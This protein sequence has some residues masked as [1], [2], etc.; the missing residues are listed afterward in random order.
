MFSVIKGLLTGVAIVL[1]TS[2]LT[3]VASVQATPLQDSGRV[4]EPSGSTVIYTAREFITMDPKKPRAEAVAVKDGR[5]IAVGTRAEVE[6]A[7]GAGARTDTT[8][9]DRV[10]VPGLIEQHVHPLLAALT[11]VCEVISIEDWNT[12]NGFAPKALDQAAYRERL[13]KTIADY[14]PSSGSTLFTWGYHESWHGPMSRQILDSMAPDLP[15]AVWDRST[16]VMFLNTAAM[17]EYEIDAK[18]VTTLSQAAQ[19]QINLETGKFLEAGFFEGLMDRIAKGLANPERLNRGLEYAERYF[20]QQ[21]I[22]I[23][24]EPAGPLSKPMQDAINAVFGDDT[25]P[26]NFFYIPDGRMIAARYLDKEGGE[27]L[28][29][30]HDNMMS[31]G[32]GRGHFLPKQTKLLMDGAIFSQ[33]QQM[34]DGY[35]DD[36]HGEWIQAPDLF[37]RAFNVYWSAGYQI[38]VHVLG[39]EGL[40]VVLDTLEGAL[41]R[42]PRTDHRTTLVHFAYAQPDQIAR[43]AKLGAIV[44]ANPSYTTT[45]ADKYAKVGI[46]KERTERMVP[47]GET[48]RAGIPISLHSDMPMGPASPLYL[49]WAAVNRTTA[50]GWTPGPDQRITAGQALEAVTLGAA[51]SIRQENEIGSITVG[52]QANLTMLGSNPLEVEPSK[53]KD[54]TVWGT[55]LEGRVQPVG[56]AAR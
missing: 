49:M 3:D 34:R 30:E 51:Y 17:K 29:V 37:A 13:Q 11:M 56:S 10:V 46:G 36:H 24:A 54:I 35:N 55:M 31:W 52:K 32:A 18:W 8:F 21:G 50:S 45:L 27:R 23:L 28:L 14:D 44:S 19:K 1:A 26:F 41:K 2:C 47:L 53:I 43:I 16:H 48:V 6:E 15:L 39:D 12:A 40:D 7:A 22:T 5:F 9:A 38:H 25:T 20:H 33:L 4:G 42:H